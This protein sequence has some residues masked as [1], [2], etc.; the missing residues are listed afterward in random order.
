M[1]SGAI[2][3]TSPVAELALA[4]NG[5]ELFAPV[6][7]PRMTPRLAF[8]DDLQRQLRDIACD[9]F[10]A[11]SITEIKASSRTTR[12]RTRR[13]V[14]G[15]V[16]KRA[17]SRMPRPRAGTRPGRTRCPFRYPSKRARDQ[18]RTRRRR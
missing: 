15:G 12:C 11:T 8:V 13:A 14:N 3:T 4:V 1:Y 17:T 2:P 5:F 18:L 10:E 16:A 7:R 6:P 9:A